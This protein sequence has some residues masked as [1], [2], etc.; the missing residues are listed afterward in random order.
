MP[1]LEPL[2][3]EELAARGI[4]IPTGADG[5]DQL[6]NSIPTLAH[7]P[8]I[9][10]AVS[11]LWDA[12][13]MTGVV[14]PGLKWMVGYLASMSAGC[15][16]C[17]AHTAKGAHGTGI[18][19]DKIEALWDYEQSPLFTPAERA[20]LR[21]AQCAGQVPNAVTDADFTTLHAH[22]TP[23]EIVELISVVAL[24]GFFNRFNDTVATELEAGPRSF[25]EHHLKP[26]GWDPGRHG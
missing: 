10:N 12:V 3:T 9:L 18:S 21:V 16:Y 13:M 20:A 19:P 7:R 17:S 15:R 2:S 11:G 22:F 26:H 5:F 23:A 25:A 14:D 8:E 24:Y 6:P 4:A 1:R